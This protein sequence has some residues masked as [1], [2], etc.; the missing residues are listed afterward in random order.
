M[1]TGMTSI[2]VLFDSIKSLPLEALEQVYEFIRQQ[3]YKQ[4]NRIPTPDEIA[5]L[6]DKLQAIVIELHKQY[7]DYDDTQEVIERILREQQQRH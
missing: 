4:E 2:Q 5:I 7:G 1:K 6:R 3:P